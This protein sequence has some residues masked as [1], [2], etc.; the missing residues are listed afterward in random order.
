MALEFRPYRESDRTRSFD[1]GIDE[2]SDFLRKD[3]AG[4]YERLRF[5][6]TYLAFEGEELVGFFTLSASSLVKNW[7]PSDEHHHAHVPTGGIDVGGIP[8]I[9]IGQLGVRK[10]LR[11]KSYGKTMVRNIIGFALR[12]SRRVG[13]RIVV[14][15]S[16]PDSI[17]FYESLHFKRLPIERTNPVFFVDLMKL[18]LP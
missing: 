14:V 1:C 10:D 11:G 8:A 2:I 5:G 9:L 4:H 18:P 17:G 13:I 3:E 6:Q 7:V 12:Q 15:H 16:L